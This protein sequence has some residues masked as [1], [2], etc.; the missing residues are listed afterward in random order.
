MKKFIITGVLTLLFTATFAQQMSLPAVMD[1]IAANHPVVKMYNAEVRSMDAAAKGARSWMPPTVGAGFF[2]TPYNPKLWQR[3][4][5]MLG[6]GSVA[7][8]VEQM[9]PNRKKLDANENLMKAMSSVEKEKLFAA[10]NENFQDAKK[11]YYSSIVLDKKLQVVK[12][13]EKM[14]DFMIRNAEIRYKNGLSKIS[15]YYK[16]KAALG[17]SKNMQLMYENDLRVNRI[18]LNALMGRDPL[19]PL[20]IEPEYNLNDY[21]LETFGQD[22]FY[23]NRS[24]LRGIDREINIAKLKQDLEKQNLKPEFGVKFENMFGFGGQPMQFSLMLMVK[25]PF[26]SWASGMNKANIESLKLKEEALQAQKEMMVNE[27]SG[28]AYGMRNELD[29]NK[30]QL[31]LY[32]DTI[33]PALKNNYKSMQLGY[34]QNTEELFMLYDAWEQLNMAQLEY[35][36]ILTKALQTQTEIDRL[37]ER[38]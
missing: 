16:A 31:K 38:R 6:M 25:L 30:N 24:D 5:D 7:V 21:S 26:V 14:L 13:N 34:E 33:I 12:E 1:S 37:I 29:L 36:E 28:M 8:S 20:E 15:A 17:S 35:F 3:D 10:L 4:G 2:M 27:Y 23:Q 9:L 18:R 22:L 19:A 32:E 11:L